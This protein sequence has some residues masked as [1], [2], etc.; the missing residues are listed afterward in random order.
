MSWLDIRI[1]DVTRFQLYLVVWH[2]SLF[3]TLQW[4]FINIWTA[5]A[6]HTHTRLLCG[7]A[8]I[9]CWMCVCRTWPLCQAAIP[10]SCWPCHGRTVV[11]R[12]WAAGRPI[13]RLLLLSLRWSCWRP[14]IR[15][16]QWV[17]L[18]SRKPVVSATYQ[19]LTCRLWLRGNLT[20]YL[21]LRHGGLLVTAS[22]LHE[23]LH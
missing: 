12:W 10:S 14:R 17:Y 3:D 8:S 19:I 20:V 4:N 11:Y 7:L 5:D 6:V 16:V 1:G 18:T 9:L 23:D 22:D 15:L 21:T 2:F 13:H